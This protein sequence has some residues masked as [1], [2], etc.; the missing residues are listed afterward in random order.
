MVGR[1]KTKAKASSGKS[2]LLEKAES[3]LKFKKKAIEVKFSEKEL[4]KLY[5]EFEVQKIELELQNEALNLALKSTLDIT[6]SLKLAQSV[7][8][9]G[10]W[11]WDIVKSKFY[12]SDEFLKIFG[13][14]EDV[15]HGFETWEKCLHPDD[16]DNSSGKI[17][18]AI[19]EKK[20]LKN[21]YR[22][23]LPSGEIRWIRV[24][25]RTFYDNNDVP[26][27]MVGLCTDITEL[28]LAELEIANLNYTLNSILS[29][30]HILVAYLDT[31]FNFLWVNETY[32]K[33]CRHSCD[34]FPSKNHFDLYPHQEN[35]SIFKKVLETGQPAY[36]EGKPF[37]FPDQPDRG[38]SYWDW[39]LVPVKDQNNNVISLVFSLI[40]VTERILSERILVANESNFI[41]AQRIAH[42]GSW[43]WDMI[44]GKVTWS[45]ELFCVYD[46]DPETFDSRAETLL[47]IIHPD[48]I[49]IFSKSMGDNI[50][51][52]NSPILEY[53]VIH[54][55]G[56][57]HNILA[58]GRFEF[59]SEGKPVRSYGTAQ[60]ITERKKSEA[61]LIES[62]E[63]YRK[64]FETNSDGITIML[65]E[66][67]ERLTITDL[68][69]NA[70]K[71]LGYTREEMLGKRPNDYE[72]G[73]TQEK[74]EQRKNELK[75]RGYTQ[76]E[77]ILR[78]KDGRQVNAEFKVHVFSY[79]G[80]IA[81]M[82]IA[83]D[84]TDRKTSEKKLIQAADEWTKTF[85]SASDAI[86]LL[87]KDNK[88]IRSNNAMIELIGK[89]PVQTGGCFCWKLIH[90]TDGP[91]AD[92]PAEKMKKS[93]KKE[94]SLYNLGDQTYEVTVDPIF[95]ADGNLDGA[96]HIM[97]NITERVKIEEELRKN[98]ENLTQKMIQIER[99]NN[100]SV[101]RELRM[102]EMK[103]EINELL[104]RLGEPPRYR[105]VK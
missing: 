25:G 71:M 2:P 32:A 62:E 9:S 94:I 42:V 13:L 4:Q 7:N 65:I 46:I 36:F 100:L 76:F 49:D 73:L 104:I 56:S 21:D 88:M 68:N 40:D 23:I 35:E 11:D 26:L 44:S 54:R 55:D 14:P 93:R 29:H 83:R 34:F 37:T 61:A 18:N 97:R 59:N 78:H 1:R 82:N 39:S 66:S 95:N 58:N 31:E 101:G 74:I 91:F 47:S 51:G 30:T 75:A 48:D 53:R 6:D 81:M 17:T 80:K 69:D 70:F 77:T 45:K 24:S 10:T 79:G 63:K 52:G 67:D 5:H 12:W 33:S 28:K 98:Q 41:E 105:I 43:E 38:V 19:K 87:D 64:L 102:V 22:I 103:K 50:S 92:C 85:N 57:V 15:V 72:I 84:I 20:E 27:R 86:C 3:L 60:D 16:I 96:V 99:F 89:D 90:N 8:N